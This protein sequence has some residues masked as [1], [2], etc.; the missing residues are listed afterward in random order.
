[1]KKESYKNTKKRIYIHYFT[2]KML[3]PIEAKNL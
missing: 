2:L 1:M 3:L